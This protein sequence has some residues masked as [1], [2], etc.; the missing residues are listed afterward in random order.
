MYSTSQAR[1]IKGYYSMIPH[2]FKNHIPRRRGRI[3]RPL[4]TGFFYVLGALGALFVFWVSIVLFYGIVE[5]IVT[6]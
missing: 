5:P 3:L 1:N 2:D 6:K 4:L